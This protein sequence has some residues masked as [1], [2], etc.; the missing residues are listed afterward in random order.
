METLAVETTTNV[1]SL[2]LHG[3]NERI[4]TVNKDGSGQ[5]VVVIFTL[6][7]DLL[8][9]GGLSVK[10]ID[11]VI[12]NIGPGDFSGTRVG[13]IFAKTLSLSIGASLYGFNT[14]EVM[15]SSME[16]PNERLIIP[17]LDVRRGY[18]YFGGFRRVRRVN[19]KRQEGLAEVFKPDC[20][21]IEKIV[22]RLITVPKEKTVLIQKDQ[23]KSSL[24]DMLE[25]INYIEGDLINAVRLVSSMLFLGL[26]NRESDPHKIF[27][28]YPANFELFF[29]GSGVD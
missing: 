2:A 25:G 5:G 13:V 17:I 1:I 3:D 23:V 18:Y 20:E 7:Q 26:S 8:N 10:D 22:A 28:I 4:I 27:P 19:G 24:K 12:V 11:R 21:K 16:V 9:M 14:L 6:L 29:K 15:A